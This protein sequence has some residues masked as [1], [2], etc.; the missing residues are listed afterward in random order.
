MLLLEELMGISQMDKVESHGLTL[1]LTL[2][3]LSIME[4]DSGNQ[5]GTRRRVP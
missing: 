4:E 3:M 5:L 2:L 1:T